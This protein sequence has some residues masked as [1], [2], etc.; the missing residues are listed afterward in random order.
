MAAPKKK[1]TLT[2]TLSKRPKLEAA[3]WDFRW[4]K[5]QAEAEAVYHYELGRE[6]LREAKYVLKSQDKYEELLK[7]VTSLRLR[8]IIF[9]PITDTGDDQLNYTLKYLGEITKGLKAVSGLPPS[10]CFVINR[11]RKHFPKNK[12]RPGILIRK[13]IISNIDPSEADLPYTVIEL[14]ISNYDYPTKTVAKQILNNWVD[15]SK[16]FPEQESGRPE[17]SLIKLAAYRY[18]QRVPQ[19]MN[20]QHAFANELNL[21]QREELSTQSGLER[22]VY[23][24]KLYKKFLKTEGAAQSSWSGDINFLR[25]IVVKNVSLLT[26]VIYG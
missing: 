16:Y 26:P 12:P 14:I 13:R 17:N 2:K 15:K 7:C 18:A 21:T 9:S 25:D 10:S 23:G 19:G 20:I 6:I 1:E 8:K 24:K 22:T 4:V 5:N 3:E 11:I